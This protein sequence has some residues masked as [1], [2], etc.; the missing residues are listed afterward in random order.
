MATDGSRKLVVVSE[1]M[2]L[3]YIIHCVY[4]NCEAA[5]FLLGL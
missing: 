3:H 5:D 1:D 2:R 4:F